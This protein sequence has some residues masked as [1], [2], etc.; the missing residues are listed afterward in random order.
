MTGKQ[1]LLRTRQ[2]LIRAAAGILRPAILNVEKRGRLWYD[3]YC[4]TV[5]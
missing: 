2:D 3:K 5:I 1:N 4:R